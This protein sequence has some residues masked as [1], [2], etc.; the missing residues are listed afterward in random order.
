MGVEGIGGL[1]IRARD[2]K[3]LAAWYRLHLG[4]GGDPEWQQA[5]GPTVFMPF[6]HDTDYFPAEKGWMLNLRVSDIDALLA[7]MRSADVVV[8]TRAEWDDPATGR[9]ARI[10]DPEGNPIELWQP[11]E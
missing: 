9:F 5:A 7:Q 11:P 8:E 1:F 6:P 4:V 10:H 2:P 3:A